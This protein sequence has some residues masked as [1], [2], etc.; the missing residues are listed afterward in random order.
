LEWH[1]RAVCKIIA[2]YCTTQDSLPSDS[3]LKSAYYGKYNMLHSAQAQKGVCMFFRNRLHGQVQL[4]LYT[5]NEDGR[6][7]SDRVL[8]KANLEMLSFQIKRGNRRMIMDYIKSS[9]FKY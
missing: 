1:K 8:K 3:N 7:W 6:I 4:N 9:Y 5:L 2:P